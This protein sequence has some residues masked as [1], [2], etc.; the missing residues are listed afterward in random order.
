MNGELHG[1]CRMTTRLIF[2]VHCIAAW[3]KKSGH[4]YIVFIAKYSTVQYTV[5]YS[6]WRECAQVA[7]LWELG[8]LAIIISRFPFPSRFHPSRTHQL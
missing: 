8:C 3:V 6:T 4:G 1:V 7:R 5:Q 2:C